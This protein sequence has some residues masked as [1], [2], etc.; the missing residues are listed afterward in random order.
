ML[1]YWNLLPVRVRL[2]VTGL[3]CLW[4]WAY[5]AGQEACSCLVVEKRD[6]DGYWLVVDIAQ[7]DREKF[8][9]AVVLKNDDA[10]RS[11][12]DLY[13]KGKQR[14]ETWLQRRI[15]DGNKPRE[16]QAPP[17]GSRLYIIMA[18]GEIAD[19][20]PSFQILPTAD[21]GIAATGGYLGKSR[22]GTPYLRPLSPLTRD[23]L[24]TDKVKLCSGQW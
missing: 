8:F 19:L 12:E 5:A 7:R 6:D 21:H 24:T 16:Y 13:E 23:T 2:V 11:L 10:P 22:G 20:G 18:E 9:Y 17:V 1:A 14:Q 4:A 15:Q 3:L